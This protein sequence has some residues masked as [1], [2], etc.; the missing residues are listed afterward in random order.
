MSPACSYKKKFESSP[1][2]YGSRQNEKGNDIK[3][4]RLYGLQIRGGDNHNNKKLYYSQ[5]LSNVVA[6]L[7]GVAASI[8]ML[9]DKNAYAAV[10]INATATGIMGSGNLRETDNT[11]T[12]RG[13][14]NTFTGSS[15][16][17]PNKLATGTNSYSTIYDHEKL[18][19]EFRQRIAK[20]IRKQKPQVL[21]V[22][23]SANRDFINQ[24][25]VYSMDAKNGA[26]LQGY[27]DQF[28]KQ[29]EHYFGV[30]P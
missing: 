2:D 5:E 22:H 20:A 17:D 1:N 16:A 28:N 14:Y 19:S 29:A 26:S 24:M 6:G 21:E 10:V 13:M 3:G 23:I 11:G 30:M 15:Y 8:V 9:T 12:T 27:V 18:S 25:N 4:S 7:E